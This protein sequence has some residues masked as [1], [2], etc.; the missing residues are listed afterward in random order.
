MSFTLPGLL[1]WRFRIVLIGQRVVLEASSEDQHDPEAP[2]EKTRKGEAHADPGSRLTL[3]QFRTTSIPSSQ[4][5]G[6][7][8]LERFLGHNGKERIS[9]AAEQ[10]H[11]TLG[12]RVF[13]NDLRL[14]PALGHQYLSLSLIHI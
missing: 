13:G 1:P 11:H 3:P 8:S 4:R 9:L 12:A 5:N 2:G 10:A 14:G 6:E 7:E